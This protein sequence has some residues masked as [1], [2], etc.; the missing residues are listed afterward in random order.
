[1]KLVEEMVV[2]MSMTVIEVIDKTENRAAMMCAGL[3]HVIPLAKRCVDSPQ[4]HVL[5]H[6]NSAACTFHHE[7]T[8][9]DLSYDFVTHIPLSVCQKKSTQYSQHCS[10]HVIVILSNNQ[11]LE[12]LV[13]KHM[14]TTFDWMAVDSSNLESNVMLDSMVGVHLWHLFPQ[15]AKEF[16][17]LI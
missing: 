14:Q 6:F 3:N 12:F 7:H 8:W 15:Q 11:V 1:M 2:E 13:H 17:F 9:V 10:C 4:Q 5:I 16:L